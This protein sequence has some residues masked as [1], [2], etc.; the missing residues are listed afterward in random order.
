MAYESGKRVMPLDFVDKFSMLTGCPLLW[1]VRGQPDNFTVDELDVFEG[2][3]ILTHE[4]MIA[5]ANAS[6]VE[7]GDDSP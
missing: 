2:E 7:V 1:L 4:Q 6:L 3:V 5:R